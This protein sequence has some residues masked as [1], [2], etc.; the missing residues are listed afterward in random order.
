MLLMTFLAPRSMRRAS[1]AAEMSP[2]PGSVGTVGTVAESGSELMNAVAPAKQAAPSGSHTSGVEHEPAF[3][4]AGASQADATWGEIGALAM[5]SAS[6][7]SLSTCCRTSIKAPRT[8]TVSAGEPGAGA[9][10][11][12]GA[13]GVTEQAGSGWGQPQF[14]LRGDASAGMHNDA[15]ARAQARSASFMGAFLSWGKALIRFAHGAGLAV[16]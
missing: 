9:G 3:Q 6:A 10:A 13:G 2:A 4:V 11:G 1:S 16:G 5:A 14:I 15:L 8:L 7:R 12:F